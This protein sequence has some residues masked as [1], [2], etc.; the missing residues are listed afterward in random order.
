MYRHRV[1]TVRMIT[2]LLLG[3]LLALFAAFAI[4]QAQTAGPIVSAGVG[5]YSTADAPTPDPSAKDTKAAADPGQPQ[6]GK[7]SRSPHSGGAPQTGAHRFTDGVTTIHR[8]APLRES[9]VGIQLGTKYLRAVVGGLEQGASLG[10]GLQA[11]TADRLHFVE[12]RASAITSVLLYR[13]FE[14]EVYVPKVFDTNTHGDAYFDY[15][16]RTKDNF[17][18]IGPKTPEEP[19]TDYDLEGR[20]YNGSLYHNFSHE[21]LLGGYFSISNTATYKGQSDSILST[22]QL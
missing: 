8:Y 17:F 19:R 4:C 22:D 6:S 2:S 12:L 14:G 15:L 10:L 7:S 18:G 3:S 9:W 21:F 11:T 13:R 16:R 5:Q 20:S 1:G